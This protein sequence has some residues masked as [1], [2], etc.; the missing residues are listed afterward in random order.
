MTL[1]RSESKP[2]KS[3]PK[4]IEAQVLIESRRRCCLC[5]H[6]QG[7]LEIKKGQIAHINKKRN[8]NSYDNL[9]FLCFDHHDE[10]DSVRSQSKG[11]NQG[12]IS[13]LANIALT[14]NSDTCSS[15]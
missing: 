7:D 14:S 9:A 8:D 11:G 3:I 4:A 15:D 1:P 10:Y 12:Q 5:H 6:F 13:I 2:R